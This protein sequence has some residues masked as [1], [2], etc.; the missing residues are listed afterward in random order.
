[1]RIV[2]LT[3]ICFATLSA[4]A[5]P[6]TFTGAYAG[7]NAGYAFSGRDRTAE[8]SGAFTPDT[9]PSGQEMPPSAR[10]A[11]EVL[12]ARNLKDRTTLPR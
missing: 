4:P 6:E 10:Q 7:M 11:S 8:G 5:W 2:P 1:M 3:L 12:R 9:S